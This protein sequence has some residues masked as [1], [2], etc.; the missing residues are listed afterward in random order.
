M[1]DRQALIERI[2]MMVCCPS[3]QCHNDFYGLPC[4]S[5]RDERTIKA[6]IAALEAE[7][8]QHVPPGHEI[9]PMNDGK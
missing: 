2:S 3:G 5:K 8:W 7:G 4:G 9:V 6:A 1:T